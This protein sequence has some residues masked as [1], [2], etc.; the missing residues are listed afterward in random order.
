M[1]TAELPKPG[2]EVIQQFSTTSPTIVTPRLV[3]CV[4]GVCKQII[5]ITN[6]D[7]TI[8]SEAAISS[9]ATANADIAENYTVSS[10]TLSLSVDRGP[11]QTKTIDTGVA[12]VSAATLAAAINAAGFTG[13]TAYVWVD[14]AGDNRLQLRT[15]SA[16]STHTLTFVGGTI[17][18]VLGWDDALGYTWYGSGSYIQDAVFLP[19]ENFPDPRSNM[20]DLTIESSSLAGYI[21]LGTNIR[22]ILTDESFLYGDFG[23]GSAAIHDD[24]DGDSRT[25]FLDL[26]D[27]S[28]AV[29]FLAAP[30]AASVTGSADISTDVRVHN[31]AL[32]IQLDGGGLQTITLKGKPIVSS[33]AAGWTL[34]H[35]STL[36][37]VVNGQ[38][39]AISLVGDTSLSDVISS[40]NTDTLANCGYNVAYDANSDGTAYTIGTHHLGL[41][42]GAVPTTTIENTEVS[43]SSD[44]GTHANEIFP[45]AIPAGADPLYQSN[46]KVGLATVVDP[47]QTQINNA[48]NE[49]IATAPGNFL[50]LTSN[51][52]GHESK[53]EIH[54]TPTSSTA[55]LTSLGLT[56]ANTYG[57]PFRLRTGD[58]V[59]CDDTYVGAVTEIHPGGVAGRVKLDTEVLITATYSSWYIIAANLANLSASW[60][61]SVPTPDMYEDTAGDVHFKHDLLRS[62]T[63]EPIG[64]AS[65]G[66]YLTYTAVRGDVSAAATT[67]EP[68]LLVFE[69]IDELEEAI[70]PVTPDNPLAYGMFIAMSN[71]ANTEI[72]GLGVSAT[73]SDS[74]YGT[75][76]AW[77]EALDF[78]ETEDVYGLSILTDDSLVHQIVETHVNAMSASTAKGERIG[79]ICQDRP[80]REYDD[81]A[82]SGSDGEALS[83]TL[84][85][86]NNPLLTAG[87]TAAGVNPASISVSDGVYLDIES[88]SY[89]WNISAVTSGT[90]VTVNKTFVAGENDDNFYYEGTDTLLTQ[91]LVNET[92][93]VKVRG[94]TIP[95]TTAGKATEVDTY[96][97][98]AQSYQNR[99]IWFL[100][101]NG[102]YASVSGVET[103][104]EGF[105]LTSAKVGQI[106]GTLPSTPFTNLPISGFT[107]VVGT[108]DRY[109][110][111]HM[112]RLAAGGC[113]VIIQ[114][115]RGASLTSRHQLTTNVLSVETREQSIVKAVDFC[116]KF[117]RT[118]L[119]KFIGRYNITESF[120]DTLATVVQG[121]L[122]FLSENGVIAGADL[123]NIIQDTTNPDTVLVDVTL[124][125][126]Y[127]CNY[128]RVT[129]VI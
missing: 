40:I 121:Q 108:N 54:D 52:V 32:G 6:S 61:V 3:P 99:R 115:G 44:A 83:A 2:V 117:L 28:G 82:A 122:R 19:T 106:A 49:T 104:V 98:I 110:E 125:V 42:V 128:I 5:E 68:A 105:F 46:D 96:V 118:G 111:T 69:D 55:L 51:T 88:D 129:L 116:A 39:R 53:I 41:W 62:S 8:N 47:I 60:G 67:S 29:N 72:S 56:A 102:A 13:V 45:T 123:N 94:D 11:T 4:V 126:L 77:Q 34:P 124:E 100:V 35:D 71:A 114:P 33:D 66:L 127:P 20:D 70:G 17:A 24:G 50:V 120:L 64:S 109:S 87:L 81:I 89:R 78:L 59:Y 26:A 92:Y 43:V 25:P 90:Q 113:D 30:S 107:R 63:G 22:Q 73:S 57:D 1:A 12:G 14:T 112:N 75:L 103:L 65:Q 37:L 36:T 86:T 76:T 31:L 119:R 15:N 38:T 101:A 27:A 58:K 7:G 74:P 93:S 21:N 16:G 97:N 23:A 18:T 9:P 95:S 48:M 80:T 85:E 10:L 84:F 79:V 91:L